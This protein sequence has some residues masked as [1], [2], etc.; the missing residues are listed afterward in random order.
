MP[1]RRHGCNNATL[2]TTECVTE[3][4]H[5]LL[6]IGGADDHLVVPSRVRMP[7]F[8]EVQSTEPHSLQRGNMVELRSK[9]V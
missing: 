5:R 9:R 3:V 1:A 7:G 6:A 4:C 2:C 8:V